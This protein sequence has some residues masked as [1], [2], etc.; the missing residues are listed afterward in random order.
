MKRYSSCFAIVSLLFAAC[1]NDPA[2]T[3]SGIF[4][5]DTMAPS[6]PDGPR[7]SGDDAGTVS[8]PVSNAPA[9]SNA[10]TPNCFGW[11]QKEFAANNK[12]PIKAS[13]A[14]GELAVDFTLKDRTGKEYT[15]SKLLADK[16]VLLFLGSF[17]C[18]YYNG[19]KVLPYVNDLASRAYGGGS[20]ADQIH[21]VHVYT[22]EAHPMSP[23]PSPYFGKVKEAEQSFK[24]QATTYEQRVADAQDIESQLAG[25]QILLVDDL[26]LAQN[27][28]PVW[29]TYGTVPSGAYLIARDGTIEA[30]HDWWD[31]ATMQQSM[32][33]LL[34]R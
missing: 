13:L 16:P 3:D 22:I 34:S 18:P 9:L 25:D 27:N 33:Y 29:C 8:N 1:G 23:D 10:L 20:F 5:S 4:Q 21:F 12:A 7:N 11:P 24:H 32:E 26:D 19:A 15:L 6:T 30:V 2:G 28:N 17:T 31:E 14:T